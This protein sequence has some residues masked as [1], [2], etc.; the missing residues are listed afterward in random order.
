VGNV[1]EVTQPY[2][3]DNC[4]FGVRAVDAQGHRG[5]PT[6]PLPLR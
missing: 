5:V 2:S 1:T 6:F 3:K 4:L